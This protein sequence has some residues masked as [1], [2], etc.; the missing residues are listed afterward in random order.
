MIAISPCCYLRVYISISGT[1]FFWGKINY[2]IYNI[3]PFIEAGKITVTYSFSS[4]IAY[5]F[6][7]VT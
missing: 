5:I 7:L 1:Y 4:T 3:F 6:T 2:M